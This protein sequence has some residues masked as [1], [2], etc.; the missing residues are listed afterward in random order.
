MPT[1]PTE[2]RRHQLLG[3][4][5]LH[6]SFDYLLIGGGLSLF[7]TAALYLNPALLDL[8]GRHVLMAF[9]FLFT[10]PHFASSTLRLYSKPNAFQQFPVPTLV[11]PIIALAAIATC[12]EFPDQ[13]GIHVQRLYLTWS[14]YHYAAQSYGL[15][16]MYC[17]RS[18]CM[19]TSADKK[20]LQLSALSL[21]AWTFV[22]DSAHGIYWLLPTSWF[23]SY[24]ILVEGLDV[25]GT[26]FMVTA[27]SS[28]FLL[29]AKVWRARSGPMP[30]IAPLLLVANMTWWFVLGPTFKAFAWATIFHGIQYLA[31]VGI[32]H[33]KDRAIAQ[34][35]A[36]RPL[37]PQA[38]AFF[39][40]CLAFGYVSFHIVPI[41]L[42]QFGY[43]V[44]ETTISVTAIINLHHFIV[45]GYIWRLGKRDGNR[46]IVGEPAKLA[47][48]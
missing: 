16:V 12:L 22:Q 11:F 31:I 32:F 48:A 20:L 27:V 29:Y 4:T 41:G 38:L 15:A 3:R 44:V 6:P 40:G 2:P 28:P 17:Y 30:L 13:I 26:F 1:E 23:V 14:P 21:F 47:T 35:A 24:P 25:L 39:V 37:L 10:F 43:G 33:L 9:L 19:L 46:R 36:P 42:Q 45:D 8:V 5:F 7:F 18:G 34:A